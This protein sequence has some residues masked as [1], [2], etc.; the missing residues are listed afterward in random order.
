[1]PKENPYLLLW[2][3]IRGNLLEST[4]GEVFYKGLK[5]NKT[6]LSIFVHDETLCE[7]LNRH[8]KFFNKKKL[9]NMNL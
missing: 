4:G 1:M 5:Q 6:H 7:G 9:V 3:Q 2:M 8:D